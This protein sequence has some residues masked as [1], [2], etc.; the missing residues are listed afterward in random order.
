MTMPLM[1]AAPSSCR[2]LRPGCPFSAA[3]A[4]SLLLCVCLLALPAASQPLALSVLGTPPWS[5]RLSYPTAAFVLSTP[6]TYSPVYDPQ[7]PVTAAALSWVILGGA[8]DGT[9]NDVW[10]SQPTGSG[11]QGATASWDLVTGNSSRGSSTSAAASFPPLSYASYAYDPLGSSLYAFGGLRVGS[12]TTLNRTQSS[13]LFASTDCVHWTRQQTAASASPPV[14]SFSSLLSTSA[15]SSLLL[16]GGMNVLELPSAATLP[17]PVWSGSEQAGSWAWRSLPPS[18]ASPYSPNTIRLYE[19]VLLDR[20]RLDGRDII[21]VIAGAV[22]TAQDAASGSLRSDVWAS[23]D[24]GLSWLLL[25]TGRFPARF[26]H[27]A[28]V[29]ASGIL[30]L[31]GGLTVVAEPAGALSSTPSLSDLW[32]S[33][34]GGLSWGLCAAQTAAGAR[35]HASMAMTQDDHLLLGFGFTS[36]SGLLGQ[37]SAAR[38][39]LLKSDLALSPQYL[40][41]ACGLQLPAA[42]VGLTAW[43][44]APPVQPVASS[45]SSSSS[46]SG[47]APAAAISSSSSSSQ[48]DG[49]SS[50]ASAAS[51]LAFYSS[52]SSSSSVLAARGN[53]SSTGGSPNTEDE[54]GESGSSSAGT[55]TALLA[56]FACTSCVCLF[57]AYWQYRL[58]TVGHLCCPAWLASG[59]LFSETLGFSSWGGRQGGGRG[60]GGLSDDDVLRRVA[61]DRYD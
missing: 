7:A 6:V 30:L 21:F 59:R 52:P 20:Q 46:S 33:L 39:D 60:R 45:S 44:G 2:S 37:T 54:T 50:A 35:H 25:S 17:Q 10:L 43:P 58:R 1:A 49:F 32:A 29:S 13:E 28:V 11:L 40:A 56:V 38:L 61:N 27:S 36:T 18:T 8:G 55:L 22:Q 4:V 51:R 24:S 53:A 31:F 5:P 34:D 47:R 57:L 9:N 12:N 48:A 41:S 16:V 14:R 3:C 23:S 42:G 19:A 15:P 26:G